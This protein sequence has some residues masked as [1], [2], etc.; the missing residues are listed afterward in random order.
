MIIRNES[1]DDIVRIRQ[2]VTEAFRD[3]SHSDGNE[4]EI[5]AS[6]RNSDALS[7]SLV[8]ECNYAL[9]GHIA[10]SLIT[11]NGASVAW[12]GLGPLAVLKAHRQ[13]G[14][15]AALVKAGLDQLRAIGASGCVVL[16]DPN[17]YGRFGFTANASLR[18]AD[19]P[20]AYFQCLALEGAPVT[21][22]VVYHRAFY[23]NP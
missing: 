11:I 10:F 14:I 18:F 7:V 12:Y 9:V 2:I 19:V 17:Y 6:L 4:A 23:G 3:A 20:A 21:G 5:V 13:R 22:E 16:G 1:L 8:A 15:G